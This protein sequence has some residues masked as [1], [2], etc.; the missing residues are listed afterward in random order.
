MGWVGIRLDVATVLIAAIAIG[1]SV[2][3]TSHIMFRF[4]HELGLT[5]ADP[6]RAVERMVAHTGRAVVAS[7]AILVAGF[8][9]LLFASVKSVSYFG[10]L[11]GM[12]IGSALIADLVITPALLLTL[13]RRA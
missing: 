5:P 6:E 11:S 10:L 3:D 1:I 12:T 8:A 7:S 4:R 2:N 13:H 9:V